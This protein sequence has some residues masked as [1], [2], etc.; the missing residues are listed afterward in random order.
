MAETA[1]RDQKTEA[2]SAKRMADAARDGDILQSRELATALMMLMGAAWVAMAGPWFIRSC[3]AMLRSGLTFGNADI[4]IFD[5][6]LAITRLFGVILPPLASLLVLTILAAIAGPAALGSLGFRSAAIGFKA[7]RMNPLSGMKRVFGL[8]GLIELS[9]AI[10]KAA[11]L[12]LLGWWLVSDDFHTIM[13]LNRTDIVAAAPAIGAMIT[14]TLLWMSL[15]LVVIAGIDV[16]IQLVQRLGRLRMTKQE[17]R[18]EARQSEGAPE[19]KRAQRQRQHDILSGS[20]RKALAE[21]TLILTNPTHFAVALRYRPGLDAAPL[22]VA[23]G[24]GE[25]ALAIRMLA[26]ENAVPTLEYPS[27]ARAIYFTSRSGQSVN[28][29]LYMAVATV[30]AFVFNLE[31]ALAEGVAQPEVIVPETKR[32]DEHGKPEPR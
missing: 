23:R 12:G 25:V 26:K 5:P 6:S 17:V 19:L 30:L 14:K 13:G 1:D 32:F 18:D 9:K 10:A 11:V 27:L 3:S 16:P 22:V 8:H 29:E 31:R 21:A 4:R 2:P 7:N 24:R 20:A 15:G 28:E